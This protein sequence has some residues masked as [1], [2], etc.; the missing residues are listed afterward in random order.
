[1][2]QEHLGESKRCCAYSLVSGTLMIP[3]TMILTGHSLEWGILWF[4]AFIIVPIGLYILGQS[5]EVAVAANS[6]NILKEPGTYLNWATHCHTPAA[7]CLMLAAIWPPGS[8]LSIVF[9]LPY[10]GLCGAIALYGLLRVWKMGIKDVPEFSISAGCMF[11]AVG[12][13]WTFLRYADIRPMHFDNMIVLLTGVHFHYAGFALPIL[14]GLGA[15]L[16]KRPD[17]HN[18]LIGMVVLGIPAVAVGITAGKSAPTVEAFAAVFMALSGTLVAIQQFHLVKALNNSYARILTLTS[19]CFLILGMA[20]AFLYGLRS[21]SPM[22]QMK[23][24]ISLMIPTHGLFNSLG[25]AM[26]ALLAWILEMED[27][28]HSKDQ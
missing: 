6:L 2:I 9:A 20:L 28:S 18:V 1:M 11:I 27:D 15:R 16:L 21:F 4:G 8:A 19:G 3:L 22:L 24:P 7:L 23:L 25:F 5:D 17:R 13:G 10:L 14:A 26:P 12:G